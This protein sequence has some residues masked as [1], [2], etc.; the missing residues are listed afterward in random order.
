MEKLIYF[1]FKIRDNWLTKD[2]RVLRICDMSNQHLM[3]SKRYI[4]NQ[5]SCY[6]IWPIY[7]LLKKEQKL[8]KLPDNYPKHG[9]AE[10]MFDKVTT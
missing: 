4:E 9:K 3:N 1:I 10:D 8:R 2:G 7:K 6:H 5:Y